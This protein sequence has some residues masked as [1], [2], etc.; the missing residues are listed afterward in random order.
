M[1]TRTRQPLR[2]PS[3]NDPSPANDYFRL[4]QPAGATVTVLLNGLTMDYDLFIY[5]ST[6]E[7]RLA[8]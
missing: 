1:R 6:T 7:K 4:S 3:A 5:N 2:G 8:N